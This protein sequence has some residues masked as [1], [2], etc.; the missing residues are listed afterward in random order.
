MKNVSLYYDYGSP[1]AYIAEELLPR[2]LPGVAVTHHPIYL[3]GLETFSK[4]MPYTSAKLQYLARDLARVAEHEA[5]TLVPPATFPVDGLH[6]LRAAYVAQ[7]SGAFDRYHRATF[8]AAWA[9]QRDIGQK[10][11]VARLLAEAIGASEAVALE[12]MTASAIKDR[13]RDATARAEAR[14]VFGTPTFFVDDE[15]FWGHDR[16][17]YVAREAAR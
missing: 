4:G 3:R 10:D 5:V 13:L 14:G 15:M 17:D 7:D 1:W 12:A 16:F 8:R 2:K 6:A 11:V 9:E